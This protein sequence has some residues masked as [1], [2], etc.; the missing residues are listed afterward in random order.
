MLLS[1]LYACSGQL[2]WKLFAI[3]G[4]Y[5]LLLLGCLLY[6]IGALFMIIAYKYG[7]ISVLQ[8]VLSI[9]YVLSLTIGYFYLDE[10]VSA[11]NWIG[12]LLIIVGVIFIAGGD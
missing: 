9:S 7:S 10:S 5:F 4:D 3:K 1:A 6:C 8:P 2:F 11:L 12:C